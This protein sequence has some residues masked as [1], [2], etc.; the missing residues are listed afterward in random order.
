[1]LQMELNFWLSLSVKQCQN[2]CSGVLGPDLCNRILSMCHDRPVN[3]PI[4]LKARTG[5]SALLPRYY[6][7]GVDYTCAAGIS[8]LSLSQSQTKLMFV[9][10]IWFVQS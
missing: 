2:P 3:L 6:S 1:M 8:K 7:R 9:H 5:M 10:N 4:R